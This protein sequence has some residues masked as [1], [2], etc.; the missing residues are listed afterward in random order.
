ML[1]TGQ[2]LYVSHF[3]KKTGGL[4]ATQ[5]KA[6]DSIVVDPSVQTAL[7]FNVNI[8]HSPTDD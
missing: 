2:L 8:Y 1:I 3:K 4:N 5:T 7:D 6:T